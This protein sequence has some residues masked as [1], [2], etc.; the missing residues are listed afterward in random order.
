[1][2][3]GPSMDDAGR[4]ISPERPPEGLLRELLVC[5]D[6]EAHEVGQR[7]CKSLRFG[8]DE[9]QPGQ[10][11]TNAERIEQEIGDFWAVVERLEAIGAVCIRRISDHAYAKHRKLQK[12]LQSQ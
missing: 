6:E 10:E 3:G 12:Y 4:F 7:V 11:M 2:K 8:M 5:L 1:M 9:V